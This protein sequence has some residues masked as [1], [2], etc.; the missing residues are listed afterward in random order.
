MDR[1]L[2]RSS[3]WLTAPLL[4]AAT[5]VPSFAVPSFA[6]APVPAAAGA[7]TGKARGV[8]NAAA[9]AAPAKQLTTVRS[10]VLPRAITSFGAC[11]DGGWLYV[12]GGHIGR[13]HAHSRANV[14]GD[15]QR[16]NLADGSSW[17]ALPPGPALQGTA[18]VAARDGGIWRVGGMNARNEAGDEGDLHSTASVARFDPV[19][20][21]WSEATPLPEPRSSHDAIVLGD[22]LY[23]VG[24]W[25][26]HG[27][28]DGDWLRTAWVADLR[29][30]PL[31]WRELPDVGAP[32]RAAALAAFGNRIALLGGLGQDGMLK[33]VRV[34]DPAANAWSDAPDLPGHAFGTA[35][36]GIGTTLFA[37]VMDGR[38]L[39]W[40]GG[41][42]WR[43]V[44][45]LELP[46]FF[47][48]LVPAQDPTQILALGGAGRGGHMRSI[49]TVDTVPRALATLREFVIPAPGKVAYRQAVLLR[50]NVLWAFGGNRNLA[51]D[52]FAP[53]QFAEDVWRI[54]LL[55]LT[56]TRAGSLPAGRQSMAA[57]GAGANGA[58]LLAGGL[59]LATADGKVL[60]LAACYR[61]DAKRGELK[62]LPPL[63]SGRTQA[64]LV[65]HDGK[66]W[67]FGGTDFVPDADGGT[68]S[69]DHA[70][71]LVCDLGADA[72][73]F[74]ASGLRLPRQRRSFAAAVLGG[75]ALLVGGLG[76]EF[77]AAGPVDALDLTTRTWREFELP[78]AWVSPQVAAIGERLY[79]ACGGTMNGQRFTEDRSLWSWHRDEGWRRVVDELPFATRHVHMLAMRNRLLFYAAND[80][81]GDCIVVRT[82]APD[83]G[84]HVLE[85]AMHR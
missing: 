23:V 43:P 19:R 32:R 83:A 47:H 11:R 34:F 37:T 7:A 53:A 67:L 28:G 39:A 24:G 4:A 40:E 20:L 52:R 75:E 72:P 74:A 80:A 6:Q 31:V 33:T 79:V 49:E 57:A 85:T 38:L 41:D 48:R 64:A 63:P 1:L 44:A 22:H 60:S 59:G 71:V 42:A 3:R 62:E 5:V 56:A 51:G 68:T 25:H 81:R 78:V 84:V 8:A 65:Q 69:G 55:A 13:E 26:L 12:F 36:L 17:Q 58:L 45:Q 54:D 9:T 50:D 35:A 66:A 21:T 46:R 82:L 30:Q 16:L 76:D 29:Q 73:A 10:A 15:F 77:A 2:P 61:W 18:L 70:D 27:R 14:V